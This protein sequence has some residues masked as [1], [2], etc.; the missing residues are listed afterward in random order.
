MRL[1]GSEWVSGIGVLGGEVTGGLRR[2][3][4]LRIFF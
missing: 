4:G 1:G 3:K 2:G